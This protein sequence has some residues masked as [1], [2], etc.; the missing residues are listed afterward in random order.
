M[1]TN[2]EKL[3]DLPVG[4]VEELD[5][6]G[7]KGK[8]KVLDLNTIGGIECPCCNCI[9]YEDDSVCLNAKC[10]TPDFRSDNK[11]VIFLKP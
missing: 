6:E 5:A 4:T 3:K 2:I 1:I 8:F 7:I 11:D 9:L 10:C